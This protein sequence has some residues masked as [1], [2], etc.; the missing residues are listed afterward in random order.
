M[1]VSAGLSLQASTSLFLFASVRPFSG[2]LRRCN[3]SCSWFRVVVTVDTVVAFVA[4][5]LLVESA[6]PVV[7]VLALVAQITLPFEKVLAEL[8]AVGYRDSTGRS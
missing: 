4:G 8:V 5:A 2:G 1:S 6:E 3:G 7:V